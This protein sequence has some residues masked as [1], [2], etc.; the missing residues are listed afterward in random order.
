M[1]KD[2]K[3]AVFGASGMLG[4]AVMRTLQAEGYS[5][6]QTPSH[7]EVNLL[8]K[9]SVE[10]YFR[11][12]K[13]EFVFMVAGLVGGIGGNQKRNADFLYQNSMM[14]LNVLEAV[15]NYSIK[16]KVL[17]TGSTC[18]YPKENSQPINESRFLAG[19]FEET[20]KGYEF[21]FG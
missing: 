7:S 19:K 12:E 18:I 20:N 1:Q 5:N 14:I 10:N 4:S 11:K 8:I 9:D 17:Y 21:S 13:P 6:L 2:S 3:I 15:K 16:T